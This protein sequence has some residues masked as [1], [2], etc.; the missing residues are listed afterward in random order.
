MNDLNKIIK[1][2]QTSLF[3]SV[4]YTHSVSLFKFRILDDVF[5]RPN[6]INQFCAFIIFFILCLYRK[7]FNELLK[8]LH[9]NISQNKFFSFFWEIKPHILRLFVIAIAS[10]LDD[11]YKFNVSCH[12]YDWRLIFY[13]ITTY[14]FVN[15]LYRNH[16]DDFTV[17]NQ[18]LKKRRSY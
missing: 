6:Q 9:S 15:F 12:I 17:N 11:I 14:L 1:H 18:Q 5:L 4:V 16:A 10:C 2:S 7:L 13:S 8:W 3:I